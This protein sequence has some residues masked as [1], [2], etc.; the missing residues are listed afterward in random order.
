MNAPH[1]HVDG[2]GVGLVAGG[3]GGGGGGGV[4]GKGVGVK[5]DGG[6][7]SL[8]V[9]EVEVLRAVQNSA[10]VV[11]QAG[12]GLPVILVIQRAQEVG[13]GLD[14]GI[15]HADRKSTRLNSSHSDRSRMPSSA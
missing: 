8:K 3:D 13:R 10:L 6:A 2:A 5:G 11:V 7:G 1:G 9:H 14:L 15:A 12:L 4:G